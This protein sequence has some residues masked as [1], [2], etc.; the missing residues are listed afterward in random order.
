MQQVDV[1]AGRVR[2]PFFLEQL[3]KQ[4]GLFVLSINNGDASWLNALL[5]QLFDIMKHC[6]LFLQRTGKFTKSNFAGQILQSK[7]GGIEVLTYSWQEVYC[8]A[9]VVL[10]KMLGKIQNWL[11]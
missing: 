7:V 9:L 11:L 10:D 3:N 2:Q 1:F 5:N 6:S 8:T 4:L